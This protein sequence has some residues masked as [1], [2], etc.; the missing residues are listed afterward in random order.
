MT[1]RNAYVLV[2]YILAFEISCRYLTN[3]GFTLFEPFQNYDPNFSVKPYKKIKRCLAPLTQPSGYAAEIYWLS[4]IYSYI[5]LYIYKY[6]ICIHNFQYW[7]EYILQATENVHRYKYAIH[8][9]K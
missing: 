4:P 6:N 8:V 7:R 9:Y 1:V 2:S 3:Y 5:K